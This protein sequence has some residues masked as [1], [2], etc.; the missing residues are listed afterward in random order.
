[1]AAHVERE[2]VGAVRDQRQDAL[3]CESTFLGIDA[4][5]AEKSGHMTAPQAA[6]LAAEAGARLLVLT[7]FSQRYPDS[8]VYLDEARLTC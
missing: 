8:G 1:M 7:H 6:T 3:V 5:L 4:D 2:G